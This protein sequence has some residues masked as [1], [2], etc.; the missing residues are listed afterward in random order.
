MTS[1]SLLA[2]PRSEGVAR[3]AA[4]SKSGD[5]SAGRMGNQGTVTIGLGQARGCMRAERFTVCLSAEAMDALGDK[6]K[7]VAAEIR[8]T[9]AP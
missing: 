8:G 9:K 7:A 1:P 6:C 4:L 2:E 3:A 5:I